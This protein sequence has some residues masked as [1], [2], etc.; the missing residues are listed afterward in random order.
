MKKI[1]FLAAFLISAVT[2]AQ[3]AAST[4][5]EEPGVVPGVQYIDTGDPN[6]AHDL[7]NNAG[8]PEVDFTSTGGEMGFN[9][10]YEP[11][12]TPSEGLS[13]GD[14]VGVTDFA[15]DVTAFTDGVQGYGIGDADGNY[16]LEFD[17]VDLAGYTGVT[18]D[19]DY[20]INETGYEGDGTT[21]DSG[22]DRM[23]IYVKDLT[24]GTEIDVLNTEGSDINDLGIEGAW[25]NGSVSLPDGIMAQLVVEV[26]TNS[27]SEVLYL[28]HI[29]IDGILG[30]NDMQNNAFSIYPNPAQD[31][32]TITS[33]LEGSKTIQ[34]FDLLGNKV[35]DTN[36]IN[37]Q[38]N[39]SPL[40]SGIYLI[41]ISQDNITSTKKLIIK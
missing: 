5:F 3:I 10:R 20:F 38:L 37:D 22:N 31:F 16:I 34:V 18:L 15:G 7:V 40:T 27:G 30:V 32:V 25:Q 14:W 2:F 19:I 21:N 35:L 11:Y 29:V 28:D 24:N 4:S 13:D 26:R 6:V 1:T 17:T 23:R 12:D 39:V 9:A 33:A 41:S 8:E 36:T